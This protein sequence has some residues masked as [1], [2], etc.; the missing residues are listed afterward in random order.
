MKTKHDIDVTGRTGVVYAEN[1]IELSWPI[2][3]GVICDEN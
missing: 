1:E 3:Q 2:R